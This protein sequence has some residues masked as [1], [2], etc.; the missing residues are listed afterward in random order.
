MSKRRI[1]FGTGLGII[2]LGASLLLILNGTTSKLPVNLL[3]NNNGVAKYAKIDEECVRGREPENAKGLVKGEKLGEFTYEGFEYVK[4]CIAYSIFSGEVVISGSYLRSDL[5]GLLLFNV[6]EKDRDKF[7]LIIERDRLNGLQS[8][9]F[10]VLFKYKGTEAYGEVGRA[11]I[12]I[13]G[14]RSLYS[15][16]G[17]DT[18]ASLG[19]NLLEVI[20]KESQLATYGYFEKGFEPTTYSSTK[21]Y[22][23]F[24]APS[25]HS[26]KEVN[27][28]SIGVFDRSGQV[29]YS[30][31]IKPKAIDFSLD[32]EARKMADFS[33]QR[34]HGE[35]ESFVITPIKVGNI[36]SARYVGAFFDTQKTDNYF[37]GNQDVLVEAADFILTIWI[38]GAKEGPELGNFLD[39]FQFK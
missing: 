37:S 28:E 13:S 38:R 34:M 9:D 22:F 8:Q 14:L 26:I 27:S 7:P 10:E 1:L 2:F 12:K 33:L 36:D 39:T 32:A 6:D 19:T 35:E 17:T 11:T 24:I 18:W 29:I 5:S 30:L 3:E 4:N 16:I 23:S 21:Y 20:A 31:I 15:Q 25:G